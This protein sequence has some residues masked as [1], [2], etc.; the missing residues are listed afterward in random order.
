[1]FDEVLLR[2]VSDGLWRTG[3][4][5]S[6]N[7]QPTLCS[8]VLGCIFWN[9][10]KC[11]FLSNPANLLCFFSVLCCEEPSSG[12]DELNQLSF[13]SFEKKRRLAQE[14]T[15]REGF[16][17]RL[18]RTCRELAFCW[19]SVNSF[20]L[21][22]FPSFFLRKIRTVKSLGSCV[23]YICTNRSCVRLSSPQNVLFP[24]FY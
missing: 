10:R 15:F 12:V 9:E 2:T 13:L 4:K 17:S 20:S 1:M 19:T 6:L 3:W 21:S 7:S 24:L 5:Y 14:N 16:W 8:S 18:G 23:V 11:T 22:F